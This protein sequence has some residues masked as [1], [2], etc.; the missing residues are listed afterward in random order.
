MAADYTQLRA[1]WNAT[2]KPAAVIAGLATI[3]DF[4]GA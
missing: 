4:P 2:G 1:A 3:A